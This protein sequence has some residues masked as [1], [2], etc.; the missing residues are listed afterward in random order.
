MW[1][2][3]RVL[4][5]GSWPTLKRVAPDGEEAGLKLHPGPFRSTSSQRQN[6]CSVRHIASTYC[7]R[8]Q[9]TCSLSPSQ[10]KSA[11]Q[12]F[13][14]TLQGWLILL[15]FGRL[16]YNLPECVL[17]ILW[18]CKVSVL[19]GLPLE[20]DAALLGLSTWST[21]CCQKLQPGWTQRT[22][23]SCHKFAKSGRSSSPIRVRCLVRLLLNACCC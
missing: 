23:S 1:A 21:M 22:E 12:E 5:A 11:L 4:K 3:L 7:S 17:Q 6:E 2:S 19:Q 16:K 18:V 8:K 9:W 20:R 14:E 13:L 10:R 15:S